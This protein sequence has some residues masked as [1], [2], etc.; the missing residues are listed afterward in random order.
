MEFIV[1]QRMATTIPGEDINNTT[2]MHLD[3][4]ED[5]VVVCSG[6][7][8]E[9]VKKKDRQQDLDIFVYVS[10][11][12]IVLTYECLSKHIYYWVLGCSPSG[13]NKK[14]CSL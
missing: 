3:E 10:V 12:C 2:T 1:P 8:V 9:Q 4:E 6:E 5:T 14:N 13:F 11:L 7:M